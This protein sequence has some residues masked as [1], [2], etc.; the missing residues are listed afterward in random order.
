M[1]MLRSYITSLDGIVKKYNNKVVLDN[2]SMQIEQG[3]SVAFIGC[4]GCGKS[5]LLKIIARIVQPTTGK[6]QYEKSY[7]FHYVPEHFPK[8]HLTVK[9]YLLSQGKMDGLKDAELKE[10]IQT[11]S[12]DFLFPSMVDIP[13][14]H[15]SK[16]SLQKVGV[17]Q[18]LLK[19]PDVLLLDEPLSGQDVKSQQVFIEKI[20]ALRKK[21][22]IILMACH[23]PYL[24]DAIAD[25]V[26][27]LDGGILTVDNKTYFQQKQKYVLFFKSQQHTEIPE[28]WKGHLQYVENG[29][30]LRVTEEKCNIAILEMLQAGWNLRGMWNEN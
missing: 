23:E 5:T 21:D 19:E 22:T 3:Q 4:N 7:L 15:L 9:Q 24:I 25:Y 30:N 1:V 18:A 6:I 2:I 27:R 28:Q 14:K 12:E 8:M 10:R 17:M 29:C 13:M 26:Y 11:L 20:N 16:G